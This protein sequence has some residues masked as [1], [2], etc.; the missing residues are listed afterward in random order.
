MKRRHYDFNII[1]DKEYQENREILIQEQNFKKDFDKK[2]NTIKDH[3]E[4]IIL[5]NKENK[6]LIKINL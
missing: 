2:L 6:Y 3:F 4:K 5:Q 1:S